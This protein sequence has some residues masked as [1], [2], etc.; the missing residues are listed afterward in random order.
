M[1]FNIKHYIFIIISIIFFWLLIVYNQLVT[2][3]EQVKTQW[4]QVEN[5]YQRRADL[6]PNLVNIVKGVSKFEKSTI[7][8][9]TKA[10]AN[11]TY[12]IIKDNDNLSKEKLNKFNKAQEL[13]HNSINKLLVTV[14][15]YP[16]LKSTENFI[17]LQSQLEGTE[18][19]INIERNRFN[20]EVQH[21]NTYRNKFPNFLISKLFTKFKEKGYLKYDNIEKSPII[22]FNNN[23]Y[24]NFRKVNKN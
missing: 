6:I 19:R 17:E 12:S 13:L 21:F 4:G 2:L 22:N 5:S 15:K 20:I 8:E 7:I 16:E 9:V 10:R 18:N 3:N 1:N 14:E 11:A 23:N 24:Y